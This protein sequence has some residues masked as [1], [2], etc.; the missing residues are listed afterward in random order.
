M[1]L[2]GHRVYGGEITLQEES[3]A[4]SQHPF[5]SWAQQK[6]VRKWSEKEKRSENRTL[7]GP[8]LRPLCQCEIVRALYNVENILKTAWSDTEQEQ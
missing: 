2:W 1:Y 5:V 7:R 6:V 8:W 4:A 3:E